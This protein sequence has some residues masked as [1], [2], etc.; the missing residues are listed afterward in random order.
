MKIFYWSPFTSNVAT[1]KAVINSAYGLKKICNHKTTIINSVGEWNSLKKEIS[2]KK[3]SLT[4]QNYKL[5]FTN[6]DGY[7]KSRLAFLIIFIKSYAYLKKILL[8]EKPDYLVIHL[9]T[10]LPIILFLMNNFK[11]K[12]I[13]RISGYPKLT[14]FRKLLWRMGNKNIKFV[15]VPTVDT[16]KTLNKKKIFNNKKIFYLPD[17]VLEEYIIK[18]KDKIRLKNFI[19]NIG[20][21]TKQKN[22]ELLIR[23]FYY[24]S[25]KYKNIKLVILGKGEK[26]ND[27]IKITKDL[28]LLDKV[29][30]EG[31][32]K[33]VNEYINSSL[34]VVVSSL[35]EDPGFVMIESS[36]LKKTVISS[37]C[38]NGPKEFFKN[39]KNGFV[40][41]N[42]N[43]K[44]LIKTFSNFMNSSNEEINRKIKINY[45]NSKQY[46][47]KNHSM[48]FNKLL[49]RHETI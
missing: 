18:K 1:I 13:L 17:P 12:L 34:C 27:L 47:I 49:K 15:T 43:Q 5:K 4:H 40:F 30:F 6:I 48:L 16:R 2:K 35:W 33:N 25:R 19:L 9:I 31:H 21:L 42:N 24:I 44:S 29:I 45:I 39:G 3:I 26:Y 41:K 10:S 23:S 7:L 28:N 46:S 36:N 22:Q 32:V 37:D 20:R 8:S 14:F 38:P 11:T